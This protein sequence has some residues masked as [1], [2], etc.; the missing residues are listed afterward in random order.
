MKYLQNG[1]KKNHKLLEISIVSWSLCK[2][3][4]IQHACDTKIDLLTLSIQ[5]FLILIWKTKMY[6]LVKLLKL[7]D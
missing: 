7:A 2:Y 5:N 4:S 3:C 6:P 1:K